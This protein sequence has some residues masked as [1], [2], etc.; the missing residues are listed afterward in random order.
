MNTKECDFCREEI[1]SEAIRCPHCH[2]WRFDKEPKRKKSFDISDVIMI[3]F[4]LF[5][6]FALYFLYTEIK[7]NR[8]T[9]A[10]SLDAFKSLQ[11]TETQIKPFLTG[12]Y[13]YIA[14]FGQIKNN[15]CYWWR[16][17]YFH[18][19]IKNNNGEIINV[20]STRTD[21]VIPPH[22]TTTFKVIGRQIGEIVDNH[23]CSVTIRWA[24][25]ES[26]IR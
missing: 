2:S 7:K 21:L 5:M 23:T 15:C 12:E 20:I 8:T 3:L 22:E 18:V 13:K 9:G 6:I 17:V 26:Q 19:D 25:K 16:D 11:I 24:W 14:V 1:N 10:K 4:T